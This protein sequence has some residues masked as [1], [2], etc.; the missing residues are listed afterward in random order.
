MYVLSGFLLALAL[1]LLPG[2][3]AVAVVVAPPLR[4]SLAAKLFIFAGTV[5]AARAFSHAYTFRGLRRFERDE[6][7]AIGPLT[8]APH[9]ALV[10]VEHHLQVHGPQQGYEAPSPFEAQGLLLMPSDALTVPPFPFRA[11]QHGV[12]VGADV[13]VHDAPDNCQ[14]PLSL[15]LQ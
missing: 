1:A 3:L 13:S 12:A 9:P 6:S 7:V 14:S 2:F 15:M 5:L 11:V 10:H 8:P 4:A